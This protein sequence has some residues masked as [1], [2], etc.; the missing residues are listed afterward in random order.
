[1][2]SEADSWLEACISKSLDLKQ[3]AISLGVETFGVDGQ[4]S[5]RR[6][7]TVDK[8]NDS[9]NEESLKLYAKYTS[10]SRS[11]ME[12]YYQE[13]S[14][15]VSKQ[16][17]TFYGFLLPVLQ[18]VVNGSRLCLAVPRCHLHCVSNSGTLLLMDD[19]LAQ[20]FSP[21]SATLSVEQLSAVVEGFG[22]LQA[23]YW[24]ARQQ[25]NFE[26]DKHVFAGGGTPFANPLTES[27]LEMST[28]VGNVPKLLDE[29]KKLPS[30]SEADLEL[31]SA[32]LNKEKDGFMQ[33]CETKL[34]ADLTDWPSLGLVH[35]DLWYPNLML[36]P[37]SSSPDSAYEARII[38]WQF[39]GFGKLGRDF[40][41]LLLTSADS[42][43]LTDAGRSFEQL[44]DRFY[45][46]F[47]GEFVAGALE[48]TEPPVSKSAV[49]DNCLES[50]HGAVLW[51]LWDPRP[52]V[53][54]GCHAN[55]LAML[56]NLPMGDF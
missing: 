37:S 3:A 18:R 26:L 36:R 21:A 7:V 28:I 1:M 29:L 9:K 52:D 20:G 14:Y 40:G 16:E 31:L 51:L 45:D 23:A 5:Y 46:S 53:V 10:T 22:R 48:S 4:L 47:A 54:L 6:R 15:A 44:I 11:D 12:R 17:C 42:R 56:R 13:M 49:R 8:R 19:L 55:L 30:V 33:I 24:L 50:L 39:C 27:G 43:V 35:G 34:L 32:Y 25:L 38:D 2:K 41:T